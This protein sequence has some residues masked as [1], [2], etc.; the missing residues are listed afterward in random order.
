MS[1]FKTVDGTEWEIL[2]EYS[3]QDFQNQKFTEVDPSVFEGKCI[4]NSSF[5]QEPLE[6]D[7][8]P[9]KVFPDGINVLRMINCNLDNVDIQ[10]GIDFSNDG[11][12]RCCNNII[13][14]VGG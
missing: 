5:F 13:P 11:W 14:Y 3:G 12:N 2:E 10:A 7:A 9:Y 4:V 6:N 1:I 8:P